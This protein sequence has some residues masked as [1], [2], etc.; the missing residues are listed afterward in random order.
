MKNN[1]KSLVETLLSEN[2]DVVGISNGVQT[3][4]TVFTQREVPAPEETVE[5]KT[6]EEFVVEVDG[7]IVWEGLAKDSKE[8]IKKA[9]DENE[10]A[11][12]GKVRAY[13]KTK[14]NETEDVALSPKSFRTLYNCFIAE[15]MVNES[16]EIDEA[17]GT[18]GLIVEG[19]I[20]A[21]GRDQLKKYLPTLFAS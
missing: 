20:T 19:K 8:A 18:H 7:K 14:V 6:G 4:P 3:L 1:L 10:E 16:V 2:H 9:G 21:K 17:L 15:Q 5:E 13:K 12:E 11:L